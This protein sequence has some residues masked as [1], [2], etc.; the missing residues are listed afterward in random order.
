M[1]WREIY[2]LGTYY[3]NFTVR[4]L[5]PRF[6]GAGLISLGIKIIIIS[7]PSRKLPTCLS[8]SLSLSSF[9]DSIFKRRNPP[10][11]S[12]PHPEA[13][14]ESVTFIARLPNGQRAALIK[15][16]VFG[17]AILLY[18]SRLPFDSKVKR[19]VYSFSSSLGEKRNKRKEILFAIINVMGQSIRFVNSFESDCERKIRSRI[20]MMKRWKVKGKGVGRNE[21][22]T[23]GWLGSSRGAYI[24]RSR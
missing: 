13:L 8:L 18:P 19:F 11:H 7:R 1:Y 22:P 5:F 12:H 17:V 2:W 3:S 10:A 14:L 20:K 24:V 6:G 4:C 9:H 15:V 21:K 16:R 23:S